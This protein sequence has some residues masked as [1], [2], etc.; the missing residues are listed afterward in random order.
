ME[1]LL[2]I[3]CDRYLTD[4]SLIGTPASCHQYARRVSAVGVDEIACLL[5]FGIPDEEVLES[6]DWLAALI[7]LQ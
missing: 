5:D 1:E 7:A 3:A 2:D 4:A 6:L